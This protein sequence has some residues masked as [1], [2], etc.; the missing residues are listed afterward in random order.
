MSA[1]MSP[2]GLLKMGTG[3]IAIDL[4]SVRKVRDP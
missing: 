2:S 1:E 3:L 4:L